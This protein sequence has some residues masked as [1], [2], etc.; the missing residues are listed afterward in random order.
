RTLKLNGMAKALE[1]Q[2]N[3]TDIDDLSF[4]ERLGLL[5]DREADEREN[6]RLT[7]RLKKARLRQTNCVEDVD[8]RTPRGMDKN[9]I[10]SLA[11]CQW[12]GKAQNV[13]ITGP[14]GVGKTYLACA[15]A[16]KAC[17]EGYSA[18]YRRMTRMFDELNIAKADGRYPKLMMT[19]AKTNLIILDDLGMAPM[20]SGQRHD[21]LE[22]MEDRYGQKS[23]IVTSQLPI[24]A[25][26]EAIGDP[27]IADAI[28]DRII[29]NAHK[30]NLKGESMRKQSNL[31]HQTEHLG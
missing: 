29:H 3:M 13:I 7:A 31:L 1:E 24:E 20:N 11:G 23:T 5:V 12:V 26:H 30:I 16:H 28:L 27:T 2:L 17:L 21:L 6:K 25:W 14:T 10:L 9:L 22:L 4:E 19:W 8:F 15:L 18:L